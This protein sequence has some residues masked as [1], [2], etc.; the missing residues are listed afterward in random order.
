MEI[1]IHLKPQV[2]PSFQVPWFETIPI[3]VSNDISEQSL[4][5]LIQEVRW[6]L[7]GLRG[8]FGFRWVWVGQV[9][10]RHLQA[11]HSLNCLCGSG[12][13]TGGRAE[14][15]LASIFSSAPGQRG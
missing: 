11:E 6:L 12:H 2:L 4:E 5:R 3:A 9:D 10:T 1:W 14:P 7:R 13:N 15:P 8:H